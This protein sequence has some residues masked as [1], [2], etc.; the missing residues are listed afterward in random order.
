MNKSK[1]LIA[2]LLLTVCTICACILVTAQAKEKV[3][4]VVRSVEYKGNREYCTLFG[5]TEKG[6]KV[7]S[8]KCSE[9]PAAELFHVSYMIYVDDVYVIDGKDFIKLKLQN[10][11]KVL[12]KKNAFSEVPG[13]AVMTADKT[14]NLYAT[15][16]YSDLIFKISPKG[17]CLWKTKV[18]SDCYWPVK[19]RCSG[20]KLSIDYEGEGSP[21]V[22]IN[23]KSGKIIKYRE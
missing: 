3:T 1:N 23:A 11:K 12:T 10:G 16:Y 22:L 6:K 4:G 5:L 15:G 21:G 14:G 2:V 19:I 8:Y 13:G 17:K 20:N 7:W 18:K 9:A